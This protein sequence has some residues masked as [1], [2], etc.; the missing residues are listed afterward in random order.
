VGLSLGTVAGGGGC[1]VVI[2][3]DKATQQSTVVGA[4]GSAG[5]LCV[6]VYD[7]LAGVVVQPLTFQLTVVHP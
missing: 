5:N 3:N 1:Q 7:P 4:A 2:A 6:R